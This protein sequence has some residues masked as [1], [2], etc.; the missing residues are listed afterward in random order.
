[1]TYLLYIHLEFYSTYFAD[2]V[3]L[4]QLCAGLVLHILSPDTNFSRNINLRDFC[5]LTHGMR[6]NS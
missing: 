4:Q 1:M 6:K 2:E 3:I 5:L